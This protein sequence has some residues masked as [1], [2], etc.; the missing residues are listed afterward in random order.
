MDIEIKMFGE[1]ANASASVLNKL[2]DTISSGIGTL[3]KPRAIRKEAEARAYEIQVIS[4]ANNA[5][6]TE[7]QNQ[8][9]TIAESVIT[10]EIQR[11]DTL[12]F[13]VEKA[14]ECLSTK[15]KI[16]EKPV[17]PDWSTRFI[18][19]AQDIKNEDMKMMWAKI[20]ADEVAHP[21]TYSLRTLELMKNLTKLDAN[22]ITKVFH[23]VF[24]YNTEPFLY[25]NNNILSNHGVSYDDIQYLVELGI[26]NAGNLTIFE[27]RS[28]FNICYKKYIAISK[29]NKNNIDIYTL[30]KVGKEIYNIVDVCPDIEYFKECMNNHK[31]KGI[32]DLNISIHEISVISENGEISYYN[33]PIYSI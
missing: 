26:L 28:D 9:K 4:K 18:S 6:S 12:D 27:C 15:E 16:S 14:A 30:T 21:D 7:A 1:V 33:N 13:I 3:Y 22:L 25:R 31:A 20:L 11:Q 19:I 10:K 24:T 5:L 2:I 17:D 8:I 29:N 23:L 32:T